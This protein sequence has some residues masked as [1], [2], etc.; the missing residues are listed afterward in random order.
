MWLNSKSNQNW[1]KHQAMNGMNSDS[2]AK[3]EKK[4][5]WDLKQD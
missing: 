1:A 2:E 3:K 4:E 5:E